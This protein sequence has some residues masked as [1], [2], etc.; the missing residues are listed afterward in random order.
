MKLII[1]IH[2][3]IVRIILIEGNKEVDFTEFPEENNLSQKLL[4]EI[5]NLLEK[6]KIEPKDLEK[7]ELQT[8]LSDNFTTY[9]IAKAIVD[10]LNWGKTVNKE[11]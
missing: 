6:N 1:D 3:K 5:A 4:P 11:K 8:N 2:N 9:R 10:S 7:T